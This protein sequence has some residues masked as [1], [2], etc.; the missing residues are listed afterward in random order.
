MFHISVLLLLKKYYVT[1]LYSAH[2]IGILRTSQVQF[3]FSF[4]KF[5]IRNEFIWNVSFNSHFSNSLYFK[6]SLSDILQLNFSPTLI[7]SHHIDLFNLVNSFLILLISPSLFCSL[8]L[9]FH[10]EVCSS[11]MPMIIFSHMC[12][13]NLAAVLE[14]PTTAT[15]AVYPVAIYVDMC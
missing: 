2:H 8:C 10:W 3:S 13:C 9:Q 4:L 11:T 15:L 1:F 12:L 7:H 14:F 5:E 6:M